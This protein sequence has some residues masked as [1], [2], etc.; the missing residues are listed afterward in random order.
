M[1]KNWYPIIDEKTCIECGKCVQFCKNGVYDKSSEQKPIVVHPDGCVDQCRGCATLCPTDSIR[2]QGDSSGRPQQDSEASCGCGCGTDCLPSEPAVT[3]EATSKT[4]NIDF[5]YLDLNVCERCIATGD[6]LVEAVNV[7]APVFQALNYTVNVNKINITTME[8]AQQHRFV[9]SP[10]IRVNGIDIC[11]EVKEN[12]CKDSNALCGE[13]ADCRVF[14]YEGKDYEQPPTA[15]IVDG[16]LRILYGNTPKIDTT[17]VLPENLNKYFNGRKAIMTNP[18]I[19][20]SCGCSADCACNGTTAVVESAA[21]NLN[22]D[23]L[24]LDLSTCERCMATDETLKQALKTLSGVFDTLGFEAK[25]N[26]VNIAT[27]ELAEE[28]RFISSP[29]IRVNGIDI[30]SELVESDCTDCGD[31]CGDSVDCRVFVYEGKHYEQPPVPMIVDGILK[32]IY[33]E[34]PQGTE[35]YTLPDNLEKFFSGK[36]SCC[37]TSCDCSDTSSNHNLNACCPSEAC[38]PGGSCC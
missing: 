30:C 12:Y 2:Y 9:S 19:N 25:I 11:N 23:F 35:A 5:L 32:A 28:Y 24:Y 31:L 8:L 3:V 37:E 33:E 34:Q 6:T 15:M 20:T 18:E 16:I 36:G 22:I 26:S 17:Y 21:K 14:V 4:L 13:N 10:T 27:K 1:A 29:T 38:C 7:L